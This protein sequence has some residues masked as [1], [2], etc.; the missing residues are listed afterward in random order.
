MLHAPSC[1]NVLCSTVEC[2]Y[3]AV[4]FHH[5]ITYGT[6]ITVADRISDL[7]LTIDIPHLALMGKVWGVC[8]EN[9][10]ENWLR[11]NSTAVY[12][13]MEIHVLTMTMFVSSYGLSIYHWH[14]SFSRTRITVSIDTEVMTSTASSNE[15][16]T[17]TRRMQTWTVWLWDK[18][19]RISLTFS[20][21]CDKH[22]LVAMIETVCQHQPLWS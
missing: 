12:W 7:N 3:N 8:W 6:A 13:G 18:S 9:Y 20:G 11:Y 17:S 16:A 1:Y 15:S 2:H 19:G 21:L 14:N 5:G 4:P 22:H 10:L